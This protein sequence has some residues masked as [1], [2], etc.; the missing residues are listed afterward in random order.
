VLSQV[1]REWLIWVLCKR[2]YAPDTVIQTTRDPLSNQITSLLGL[3]K[4]LIAVH[5]CDVS[6]SLPFNFV[7]G[8]TLAEDGKTYNTPPTL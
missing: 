1:H 5:V 2:S 4:V 7:A 3:Y 6:K 8:S